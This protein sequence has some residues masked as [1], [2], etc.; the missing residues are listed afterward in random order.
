MTSS[1]DSGDSSEKHDFL[2]FA[3]FVSGLGS[4]PFLPR[5]LGVVWARPPL[6]MVMEEL[7]QR[8][9]LGFLWR[10]RQVLEHITVLRKQ[11]VAL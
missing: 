3:S 10:C 6:M 2:G 8:E 11:Q 7:H 1:T 9:L 4:H 5:M